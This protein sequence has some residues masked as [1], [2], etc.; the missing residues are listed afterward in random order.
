M[1]ELAGDFGGDNESSSDF[2]DSYDASY[3]R[4]RKEIDLLEERSDGEVGPMIIREDASDGQLG[5]MVDFVGK[6]IGEL[7]LPAPSSK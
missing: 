4:G 7:H 3:R 6:S 5:P 1:A 2:L